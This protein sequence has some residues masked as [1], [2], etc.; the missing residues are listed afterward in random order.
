MARLDNEDYDE[1]VKKVN[2]FTL[3]KKLLELLDDKELLDFFVSQGLMTGNEFSGSAMENTE[4]TE[5]M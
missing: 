3:P 1:Y 4:E 2:I 5:I